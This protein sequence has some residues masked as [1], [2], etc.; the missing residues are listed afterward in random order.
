MAGGAT[1]QPPV[2]GGSERPA[3][4]YV[5]GAGR[6]GSTILGV[7]LGNC[8]GIFY[9][10][11][12]DK[13]LV[14]SGQPQLAGVERER[15]WSGVRDR[16]GDTASELFGNRVHRCIERSS[17]LLRL[18]SWPLAR[19]LRPR[20]RRVTE[21]LYRAVALEAGATH[22]V[23]TSHYPLRARE[24]QSLTGIDLYLIFLVR[25]PL[26]IVQSFDRRDVA[27]RRF[28]MLTTNAYLW[29]TYLLS[30]LVFLRQPRRRRMFL[31]HEDL[32]ADPAHVLRQLLDEVG[33]ACP[34][35][36][37]DALRTGIPL[38]GNRLIGAEVIALGR[39]APSIPRRSPLTSLLQLPWAGVFAGLRPSAG[40]SHTH[41]RRR[42]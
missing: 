4:L 38:Q 23:D 28:G 16:V 10:G 27:E 29:L 2:L 17:A 3:V 12:L 32:I 25:N 39:E 30:L 31:R 40:V 22:I 21:D 11:E 13:W 34:I 8:E 18:R 36:D 24:L 15:F 33:L 37:L 7:A 1:S 9:A 6:S 5:M 41:E 14:R 20:Y 42:G 35:P 19:R 26:S